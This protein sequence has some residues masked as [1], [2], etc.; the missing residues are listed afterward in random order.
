MS[1]TKI[2]LAQNDSDPGVWGVAIF[3][4]VDPRIDFVSVFV[5]GLTNAF[6]IGRDPSTPSRAKTLQLNFSRLGDTVNEED[7]TV[8]YGIPLVDNPQQQ[9]LICR[10][11]DLPGPLIRVYHVNKLAANRNVLVAEADANVSLEDFR[12]KITP[13][14]DQGKLPPSVSQA[15]AD[16][17]ISVNKQAAVQ[18]LVPGKRWQFK[19]GDDEYILALEPQF[20]ERDR[21]G[22]RFLRSLD[23]FWIYR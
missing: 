22:I 15:I 10:R 13:I 2:P 4:N 1:Q 9:V 14:L 3:E 12:S 21:D 7:D 8:E 5:K 23:H 17:G 20:W 18:T 6:R 19:E 16:S 11:Y